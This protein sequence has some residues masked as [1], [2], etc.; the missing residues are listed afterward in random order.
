[1]CAT[2][3]GTPSPSTLNPTQGKG[4]RSPR[5]WPC[6][7]LATLV[8]AVWLSL[9]PVLCGVSSSLVGP[10]LARPPRVPR[11]ASVSLSPGDPAHC[12]LLARAPGAASGRSLCH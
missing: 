8:A 3:W 1:M 2:S 6:G 5:G 11:V 4:P 12:P 10:A 7:A 9:R